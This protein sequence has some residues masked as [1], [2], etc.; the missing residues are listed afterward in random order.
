MAPTTLPV[1]APVLINAEPLTPTAFAPFGFVL[2]N[3]NPDLH[4]SDPGRLPPGAVRANQGSALKYAGPRALRNGYAAAPSAQPGSPAVSIFMCAARALRSPAPDGGGGGGGGLF[5][6]RVLERHPFTTQT[7]VPLAADAAATRYLVVV[8]PDAAPRGGRAA[9]A[10]AGDGH[11]PHEPLPDVGRLRAFVA[12]GRQAVTYA[13]GTWHAPMV[14]L[15][16]VGTAVDF[17]VVQFANGVGAEDCE[18]V[19]LVG[20]A[21][22]AVRVGAAA[23]GM[24]GLVGSKAK[25]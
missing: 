19:E 13:A 17:V 15:G 6:V 16:R 20:G 25:L 23:V 7:F 11:V 4:P 18:E 22:V 1:A 10:A 21:G 24:G 3:P 8:A 14:A 9:A 2:A 12:T 5:D